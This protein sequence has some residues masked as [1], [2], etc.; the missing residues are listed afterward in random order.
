[1]AQPRDHQPM[2][3]AVRNALASAVTGKHAV[4]EFARNVKDHLAGSVASQHEAGSF[5]K[6]RTPS[7]DDVELFIPK[8]QPNELLQGWRGRVGATNS[9]KGSHAVESALHAWCLKQSPGPENDLDFV[10]CSAL[11][12]RVS[13][14]ELLQNQTLTP[15][16]ECLDR[17]KQN[18]PGRPGRHLKAYKQ[19]APL[20][21]DGKK[22]L[23]CS[24][25]V[26]ED[27]GFWG[28]SYWRRGHHLP[29]VI[30]C[31]TH[32]TPLL[33]AGDR[34]CFDHCPDHYMR[35]FE[36]EC[37]LPEDEP[38]KSILLRYARISEEILESTPKI[39]ST[40][41]SAI[42]REYAKQAG[43]RF[44]KPGTKKTVSTRLMELLPLSWLT[45]TF[46]RIRWERDK[47]IS[48]VDGACVP[49]VTR[50]TTSILCLLGAVFYDDADRAVTE[51]VGGSRKDPEPF[52]GF[53]FWA[54]KEVFDRYCAN[55][56]VVSR[57]AEQIG[58][59]VGTVS[60]GLLNQGLPGL[61]KTTAALKSALQ[62]F[63]DGHSLEESCRLGA[64][65]HE[66]LE[67]MLRS[68]CARLAK[69]LNRMP[70]EESGRPSF[71]NMEHK[72]GSS[73]LKTV[74]QFTESK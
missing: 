44:L 63:F 7:L 72:P 25:C 52:L 45:A 17:L 60:I 42:I 10:Q 38:A 8:I 15:Y 53:D 11:A 5:S 26:E 32:A 28:I 33:V 70:D 19:H 18:K 43:L 58:I 57:M 48:T 46:P 55:E 49:R 59:S 4:E 71:V 1:M 56:G 64:V 31:S 67:I 21:I 61:G 14:Q 65:S 40:G 47:Y 51:L 35:I 74:D 68:G 34:S 29:G 66:A 36:A 13:R 69:A 54:S 24:K 62:L 2:L 3:N 73:E 39:D 6:I 37:A 27:L 23:F 12:L 22:A 9:L 50:Y 16:F 41:A 30:C 20:R